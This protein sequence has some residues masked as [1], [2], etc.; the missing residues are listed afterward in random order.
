MSAK[1]DQRMRLRAR[2]SLNDNDKN[3]ALSQSSILS[4]RS[5]ALRDVSN[6]GEKSD[7]DKILTKSKGKRQRYHNSDNDYSQSIILADDAASKQVA[8]PRRVSARIK[9]KYVESFTSEKELKECSM[10][11]KRRRASS[12]T[13][14]D[15]PTAK[16]RRT[17]TN[18]SQATMRQIGRIAKSRIVST[19]E[20]EE[21]F[22]IHPEFRL[23]RNSF[24]GKNLTSGVPR[25][26]RRDIDDALK[27]A[28]YATDLFQYLYAAEATSRPTMYMSNQNDI[29]AKMRAILVDW[30]VEVHMKF[31]L[32]PETLFLCVNIIDRYCK[33]VQ[34][35]RS[36]LQLVGVTALLI[37]CKYEEI[38]PPEVRD[39]VYITDR[40][41]Q[42][43]EVLDMEQ[44]IVHKLGFR[45]TVPT[46][47]PF[48]QRFLS[49][50][51]ASDLVK[52]AA[53]YYTE[54]TLQEHDMLKWRP[55]V[56]CA[57]AL[58][59][60]LNHPDL[61]REDGRTFDKKRVFLPAILMEYTGFE[62]ETIISCAKEISVKVAE[63]PVTASRRELIAVKKKY[64]N[65]KY[66]HVSTD[67]SL[68]TIPG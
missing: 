26:D 38:Y 31:R 20:G 54:R 28:S 33:L 10:H 61:A 23:Q 36:S 60:A 65:K 6:Q 17:S 13:R 35:K 37:A 2:A 47:F 34:I 59:L 48:L 5:Y 68:P 46:A 29:N 14:R 3:H 45:I 49:I 8:E 64:D 42:S 52:H 24:N 57:S 50:V 43:S 63:A 1:E 30:L 4:K 18:V 41:Y 39:C 56:I 11:S 51:D 58:V 15:Q 27:N 25:H 12:I 53:S 67:F 7:N 22:L 21:Q 55:S 32:V 9:A 16:K 44:D 19:I 62:K 66:L 40:A